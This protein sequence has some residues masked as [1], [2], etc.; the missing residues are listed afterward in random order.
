MR[1]K[2]FD[3]GRNL[4]FSLSLMLFVGGLL[5]A[6]LAL[7]WVQDTQAQ[8]E[9]PVC[10]P[11]FV[12]ER[13]S[14]VGC[15]QE[16]C[17]EAGGRYTYESNCICS[18]GM[19]SC[20]EPVL[21]DNFDQE[22]CGIFCPGS[23]L[24]A[25]VDQ[26]GL[27]PGE[28]APEILE[29][30]EPEIFEPPL[31]EPEPGGGQFEGVEEFIVG[32]QTYPP[33]PVRA[34]AA[35]AASTVMLG[36]W[37][38]LQ[39]L[40]QRGVSGGGKRGAE[41]GANPLVGGASGASSGSTPARQA[42]GELWDGVMT[43]VDRWPSGGGDEKMTPSSAP[44]QR[45]ERPIRSQ[46]VTGLVKNPHSEVFYGED[47]LMILQEL[48]KL[49]WMITKADNVRLGDVGLNGLNGPHPDGR[50]RQITL[51]VGRQVIVARVVSVAYA[52]S[53]DPTIVEISEKL[54][55]TAELVEEAGDDGLEA[56]TMRRVPPEDSDDIFDAPTVF[57]DTEEQEDDDES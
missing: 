55:L 16:D 45:I 17:A 12:W 24:V 21:Y 19:K 46:P 43:T 33:S 13:M 30:T 11:G 47:A 26:G 38:L 10:P 31:V 54:A 8:D 49:P 29:P 4:S 28:Q 52:D 42:G 40:G 14:G 1:K 2:L 50:P 34:A 22:S 36:A 39:R 23:R 3:P 20:Y 9:G 37:A 7:G 44:T 15:V 51:P 27:C 56:P 48:D 18:E 35:A 53:P 41:P 25:C 32:R 57:R 6:V 5:A